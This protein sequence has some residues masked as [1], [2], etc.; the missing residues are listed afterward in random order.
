VIHKI[1]EKDQIIFYFRYSWPYGK[2]YTHDT[3]VSYNCLKG[4]P[5]ALQIAFNLIEFDSSDT[6]FAQI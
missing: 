1:S 4:S 6:L 5:R 3:M 2:G